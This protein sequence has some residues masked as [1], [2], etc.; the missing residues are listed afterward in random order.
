MR[1]IVQP[2]HKSFGGTDIV[3]GGCPPKVRE[4]SVV[5]KEQRRIVETAT[6]VRQ[7]VPGPSILLILIVSLT[8]AVLILGILWFV[9]L[10]T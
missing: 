10:R 4:G 5:K 6:E 2:Q 9:F 7:A 8:L 1:G 3:G